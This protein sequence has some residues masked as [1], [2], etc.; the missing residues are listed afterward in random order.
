MPIAHQ[1]PLAIGLHDSATFDNFLVG[2]NASACH[3]LQGQDEPFVYLWGAQACG[4]SHLLQAACHREDAQGGRAV[5]LPLAEL[6]A[7][8]PQLIEGMEQMSLVCVDDVQ[9]LRA[10]EAWQQAIFHLY[11]RLR[12]Q[13]RRL[14]AA[15]DAAPNALGLSL[16]DLVSRLGWGPVFRLTAL[17]DAQMAQALQQRAHARGMLMS[18]EV[19]RYLLA[20]GP[21]DMHGLFTLLERID[22]RS[23]IEQRRLT[24]PFVR[25]LL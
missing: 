24:I 14:I 18:D 6:M 13:G 22:E 19:A 20:H 2:G 25:Q 3:A 5:Y 9:L 10:D 7:Y 12:E 21:R 17:D 11:N 8:S 23:L 4:K 15:G 16:L 1:L